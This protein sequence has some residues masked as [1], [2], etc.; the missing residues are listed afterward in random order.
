MKQQILDKISELLALVNA[1]PEGDL[2]AQLDAA[3][4][5]VVELEG[6][7]VAKDAIIADQAAKLAS[8]NL[9]AKEIDNQIED[10]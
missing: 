10:V 8:V 3:L 7:V 6:I 5:R 9:L 1:L 4:L 2:Q